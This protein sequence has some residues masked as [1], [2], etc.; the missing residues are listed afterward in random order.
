MIYVETREFAASHHCSACV[1]V[2]EHISALILFRTRAYIVIREYLIGQIQSFLFR[3]CLQIDK[4][5]YR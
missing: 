4:H 3:G 1:C 2:F 5:T